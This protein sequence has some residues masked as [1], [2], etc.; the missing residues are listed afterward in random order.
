ME[1]NKKNKNKIMKLK[2]YVKIVFIYDKK[3]QFNL[4]LIQT[5]IS[6]YEI[7]LVYIIIK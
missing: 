5:I 6:A 2:N 3:N 7:Y 1:K 4:I